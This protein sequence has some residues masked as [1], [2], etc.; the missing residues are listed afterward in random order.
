MV[1]PD[2]AIIHTALTAVMSTRGVVLEPR[3]LFAPRS[4]AVVGASANI[5]GHAGRALSNLIRTGF[6]GTIFPVNPKYDELLGLPCYPDVAAIPQS[7]EVAYILLPAPAAVE[8]VRNSGEAGVKLAIVCSSGFSELGDSGRSL[9][10]E[11]G[12]IAARYRI[13]VLGPNC[14]GIISPH[15]N[16]VGAPTFNITFDYQPG[17]VSILSHSGGL[18]VTVFNRAQAAGLGVHSMVSLGNEADVDVTDVLESLLV[19]EAVT[20]IALVIEQLRD[21]PE[22]RRVARRAAEVGKHVIAMKMGRSA[23]GSTAVA[24]HTGALAGSA[25]MFSTLLRECG[26]R[27]ATSI[28][29]LLDTVH[30]LAA[31]GGRTLGRRIGVVSPSGGETVYVADQAATYGL[32]LP[33]LPANLAA[34]ISAWMPLGNPANPLDLTGQ[35][36]G[37]ATLLAKVLGA[38]SRH[39]E[40]DVLMLSLATWGAYDADALLAGILD[41]AADLRKQVMISAW[42]AGAMTARVVELL[43]RSQLPW[44]PSPDRA[45]AALSLATD[46]VPLSEIAPEQQELGVSR[47]EQVGTLSEHAAVELLRRAGLPMV[48]EALA[49]RPDD[50]AELAADWDGEV[51][52]KLSAPDIVHKT[53]LGLVELDLPTPDA[54]RD[55][56]TRLLQLAAELGISAPALLLARKEK[57]LEVIVGA[58]RDDDYGPFVLVGA[59][60][61]LAEYLTDTVMMSAPA[62]R[63]TIRSALARLRLWPVLQGVRGSS[64]DVDALVEFV[65][66]FSQCFAASPWMREVDLNPVIVRSRSSGATGVTAVD[67]VVI[68]IE[69]QHA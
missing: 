17:Q 33:P 56:G 61:V 36:I 53:E 57:G 58:L 34:D 18:G 50:A 29:Q 13:R 68:A 11:L 64:Y 31:T 60:G 32:E 21:P 2:D 40:I 42:D 23:A 16:F 20:T 47:P 51:V 26:V 49:A 28:D 4:V 8:A 22:F 19:T 46:A 54:V 10:T 6:S 45:L 37:D 30:L 35:I 65:A 15:G 44:F 14:I 5:A 67:A 62:T 43:T 48:D 1:C 63:S 38:M 7:P 52:L 24:G 25:A 27:E 55:A 69:P 59:G 9:Q 12:E 39:D 3:L 41:V 66:V